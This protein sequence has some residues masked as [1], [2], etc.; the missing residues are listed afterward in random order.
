[1]GI[2]VDHP[3]F[4]RINYHEWIKKN[5]FWMN[6][7]AKLLIGKYEEEKTKQNGHGH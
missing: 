4:K 7:I 5:R 1:M 6:F 2:V 3:K